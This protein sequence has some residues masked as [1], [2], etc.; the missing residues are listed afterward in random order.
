MMAGFWPSVID[1]LS[2][3]VML[4]SPCAETATDGEREPGGPGWGERLGC[5][6]REAVCGDREAVCGDR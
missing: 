4:V 2:G 3:L 1:T 5:G 6:D